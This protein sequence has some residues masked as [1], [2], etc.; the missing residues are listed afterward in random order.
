MERST[1]GRS[2]I[3]QIGDL[4]VG[5]LRSGIGEIKGEMDDDTNDYE[6]PERRMVVS[7]S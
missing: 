3:P 1:N 6:D 7:W 5:R 2:I 4:I